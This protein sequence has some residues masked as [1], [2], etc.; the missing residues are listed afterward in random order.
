MLIITPL[1]LRDVFLSRFHRGLR[2]DVRDFSY[3][4]LAL[5]FLKGF[6]DETVPMDSELVHGNGSSP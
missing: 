2:H 5:F 6:H 3:N 1:Y 4:Y